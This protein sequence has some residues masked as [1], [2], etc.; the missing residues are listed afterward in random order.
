MAVATGSASRDLGSVEIRF[1]TERG[2]PVG[3]VELWLF[4]MGA[5][6]VERS[7]AAFLCAADASGVLHVEPLP[8]ERLGPRRVVARAPGFQGRDVTS[9]VDAPGSRVVT[10]AVSNAVTVR[11]LTTQGAPVED[12]AVVVSRELI[13]REKTDFLD[14]KYRNA[15]AG[16]DPSSATRLV[17][18]DA[19]GVAILSDLSPGPHVIEVRHP[20]LVLV[21]RP[22][23]IDPAKDHEITVTMG[24]LCALIVEVLG[25]RILGAEMRPSDPQSIAGPSILE[26][27][28]AFKR[29]REERPSACVFVGAPASA[30]P[31]FVTMRLLLEKAGIQELR[32][33]AVPLA[34]PPLVTSIDSKSLVG[35]RPRLGEALVRILDERGELFPSFAPWR[36]SYFPPSA[37]ET[38]TRREEGF[39]VQ[40]RIG[41]TQSLPEGRYRVVSFSSLVTDR[42]S[43]DEFTIRADEMNRIDIVVRGVWVPCRVRAESSEGVVLQSTSVLLRVAGGRTEYLTIENGVRDLWLP[44]GALTMKIADGSY[45]SGERAI[46]VAALQDGERQ[47][48]TIPCVRTPSR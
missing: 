17:R 37:R 6:L 30:E 27:N 44:A 18:S 20:S 48:I 14:P 38:G 46:E 42:L 26:R 4:P 28:R 24:P 41:E 32:L 34:D 29:L 10:L 12:A 22:D 21:A 3:G 39:G 13:S 23:R 5:R 40:V 11:C 36:F 1:S 2:E 43:T 15:M 9:E 7:R 25:D 35:E 16:A 45:V 31:L 47:E 19:E 8:P 33:E